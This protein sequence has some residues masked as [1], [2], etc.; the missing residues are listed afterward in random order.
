MNTLLNDFHTQRSA[1][2]QL[3]PLQSIRT[4]I[5]INWREGAV[6]TIEIRRHQIQMAIKDYGISTSRPGRQLT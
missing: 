2:A 1:A 5:Q 6:K 4:G 3:P